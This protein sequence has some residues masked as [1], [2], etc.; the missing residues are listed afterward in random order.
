MICELMLAVL[1]V[2]GPDLENEVKGT[3]EGEGLDGREIV[4]EGRAIGLTESGIALKVDDVPI[5]VFTGEGTDARAPWFLK[6]CS[7]TQPKLR[8]TGVLDEVYGG[9]ASG[10][11][12]GVIGLR[13]RG[14]DGSPLPFEAIEF[15]PD[16]R[17]YCNPFSL[18][19]LVAVLVIVLVSVFF[20]L[21]LRKLRARTLQTERKRMADDLHDTI[22]QHLVGAGMLLQLGRNAEA[23]DILIRAKKEMRDIVWGLK[24]DDMVRQTPME[25]LREYAKEQTKSGICRVETR[26]AGLPGRLDASQ[27]RDLLLIVREAVGNAVK[28]GHAGKVAIVADPVGDSGWQLRISNDGLPFDSSSAQGPADGHFGLEGMKARAR[29]LNATM[30]IDVKDGRTVV[31]VK[32]EPA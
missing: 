25:M 24:N 8:V 1:T 31:T 32:S 19:F 9:T 14:D 23:R 2:T 20:G 15:Q 3:S 7:I 27:M 28:H 16:M 21:S 5:M 26:L 12:E 13:L 29:R 10:G 4:V 18:G 30:S 11:K 6:F 17:F 22:E